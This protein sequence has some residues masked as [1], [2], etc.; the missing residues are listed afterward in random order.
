MLYQVQIRS[1][2]NSISD[3]NMGAIKFSLST[4]NIENSIVNLVYSVSPLKGYYLNQT[5][6]H[7]KTSQ[8]KNQVYLQLFGKKQTQFHYKFLKYS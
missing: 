7:L 2:Y 4:P 5:L 6:E 8:S 1:W 3:S